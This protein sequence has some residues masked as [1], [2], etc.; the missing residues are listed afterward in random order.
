MEKLTAIQMVCEA[1][2]LPAVLM[3]GARA[4]RRFDAGF[5]PNLAAAAIKS[6]ADSPHP[7]CLTLSNEY[8]YYGLVRVDGTDEFVA[9]GP[10]RPFKRERKHA[11][12]MLADLGEPSTRTDELLNW[13]NGLPSVDLARFR[14]ILRLLDS[15]LNG[16]QGR[17]PVTVP[18]MGAARAAAAGEDEPPFLEQPY[19]EAFEREFVS[20]VEY[21]NEEQLRRI[22]AEMDSKG[23]GL[24][25]VASDALRAHKNICIFSTGIVSRAAAKAGLSG[26]VIDERSAYY[27]HRF[28]TADDHNAIFALFKRMA[29]DFARRA[30]ACRVALNETPIVNR[31]AKIVASHIYEK[32]TPT[33]IAEKMHMDRSYLCRRFKSDAGRTISTYINEVKVREAKRLLASSDAS[34]FEVSERLGFT[35]QNYFHTVFK[36]VAGQTPSEYR[37][38][39]H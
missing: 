18:Y 36:K 39:S 38:S 11:R 16:R 22:F 19:Y 1:T 2:A 28:E 26:G 10:A 6:A 15:L 37:E 7:V 5:R 30:A 14:S 32:L 13:L 23:G 3:G 27:L 20:C 4:A 12:A 31:I 24:P 9:L 29:L 8:L 33:I 35:A 17:D 34:V 25:P 21:G